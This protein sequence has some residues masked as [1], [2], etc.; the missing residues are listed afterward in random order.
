MRTARLLLGVSALILATGSAAHAPAFK[1]AL[2][3]LAGVKLS[4][5]MAGSV[6]ALWLADSTT[7]LTI[8]AIFA[9]VAVRPGRCGAGNPACAGAGKIAC[10]HTRIA[11]QLAMPIALI[12]AFTGIFIYEFLGNFYAGHLMIIAAASSF[13]AGLL[14][15]QPFFFDL[16]QHGVFRVDHLDDRSPRVL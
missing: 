13:V 11:G 2:A 1:H 4:A 9:L 16:H 5:G 7:C 10:T 8:A 3:A 12:P 14:L 15:W 6:K